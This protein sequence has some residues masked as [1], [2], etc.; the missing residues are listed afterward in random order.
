M[1]DYFESED[2]RIE[3]KSASGCLWLAESF[4]L[5]ERVAKPAQAGYVFKATCHFTQSSLSLYSE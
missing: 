2:R 1:S 5:L 4:L 3:V